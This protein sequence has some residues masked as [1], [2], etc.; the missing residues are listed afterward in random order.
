MPFY[1]RSLLNHFKSLQ[2]A[3]LELGAE[4][5]LDPVSFVLRVRLGAASRALYPQF[6]VVLKGRRQY[7]PS[8]GAAAERF[9]G[10]CPYANRRWQLS[11][12]KL[13]FKRYAVENSLLTPDYSQ[14]PAAP[15]ENVLVKS[16]VSSF[17]QGMKGPFR[18]CAEHALNPQAGEYFERF[19]RGR[20]A[21]IWY[22]NEQPVCMELVRMPSVEGN[23]VS[24]VRKLI[25]RE[26]PKIPQ[27]RLKGLE[28]ILA[29]QGT[30]LDAILPKRHV[31]VLQFRYGAPLVQRRLA[32]D[33]DLRAKLPPAFE[34]QLVDA[35]RKLWRGIPEAVRDNT[36]FSVDAVIDRQNQIWL[37]EMNSN[38]FI[39]PYVYAPML[40]SLFAV[41]KEEAEAPAAQA[42]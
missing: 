14:D 22:W 17:G 42:H 19:M 6:L 9:V 8:F 12:E 29:F 3:L 25:L 23:G 34:A 5:F 27:W 7:T 31:R 36:V 41:R 4:A 39:H 20:L 35:G 21:K 32:R 2:P 37:L 40:R 18:S 33:I 38:P 15:M 30:R 24:T 16:S 10:W 28:P 26:W 11:S 13:A 1:K